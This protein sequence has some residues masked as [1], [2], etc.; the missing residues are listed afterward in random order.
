MAPQP[1]RATPTRTGAGTWVWC[2]SSLPRCQP[3]FTGRVHRQRTDHCGT[4]KNCGRGW[5]DIA[6]DLGDSQGQP[7]TTTTPVNR[8]ATEHSGSPR[9]EPSSNGTAAS[10]A[11]ESADLGVLT[12]AS[13]ATALD[14]SACGRS[15]RLSG[16]TSDGAPPPP[17]RTRADQARLTS[18][19]VCAF[20]A[21]DLQDRCPLTT[22]MRCAAAIRTCRTVCTPTR[23]S[24][25]PPRVPR[26]ARAERQ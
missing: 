2:A 24:V 26:A 9:C 17:G 13:V 4:T 8:W 18:P 11:R 3:A 16:L 14:M 23:E 25:S 10:T 6:T 5:N 1:A 21:V 20:G 19:E 22:Q 15:R 7:T 12:V